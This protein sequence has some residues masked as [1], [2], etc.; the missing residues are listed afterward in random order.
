MR[1]FSFFTNAKPTPAKPLSGFIIR[2]YF[3]LLCLMNFNNFSSRSF[4]GFFASIF[5]VTAKNLAFFLF[6][7]NFLKISVLAQIKPLK[8]NAGLVF[9]KTAGLTLFSMQYFSSKT[10]IGA[11][12]NIFE[13]IR[14][15]LNGFF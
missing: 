7:R 13:M 5:S 15:I 1:W 3:N 6:L 11:Y 9:N 14:K 4:I 12:K 8:E 2:G 10:A